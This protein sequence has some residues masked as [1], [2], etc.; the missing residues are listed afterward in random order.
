MLWW[1]P[2]GELPTLEMAKQKL[3]ALEAYGPTPEAFDI[4]NLF[5]PIGNTIAL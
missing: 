5:D 4:R 2:E 3:E 1:L